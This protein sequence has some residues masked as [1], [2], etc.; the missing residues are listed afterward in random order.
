MYST[1]QVE[2]YVYDRL[3]RA[4]DMPDVYMKR[5]RSVVRPC[6]V[7]RVATKM[8]VTAGENN[9]INVSDKKMNNIR[10]QVLYL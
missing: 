8:L 10:K 5:I 4:C 9:E 3:L 6:D 2:H 1:D 7:W